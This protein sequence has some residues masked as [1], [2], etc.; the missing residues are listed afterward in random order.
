LREARDNVER[1]MV[2]G[3]LRRSNG[4]ITAAAEE[5]GISRPT[6]YEIIEKLQIKSPREE[7]PAP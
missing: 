3:A 6:L 7:A 2:A 1:E 5:L 4:K